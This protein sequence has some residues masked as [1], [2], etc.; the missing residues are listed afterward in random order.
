MRLTDSVFYARRMSRR[1]R[2]AAINR[3][4]RRATQIRVI[5]HDW[6]GGRTVTTRENVAAKTIR[7]MQGTEMRER[8]KTLALNTSREIVS[9]YI[10][11]T[12]SFY[13]A[14]RTFDSVARSAFDI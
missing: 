4:G 9:P 2:R 10:Q 11:R 12:L 6:N 1:P 7:A 14:F 8:K 3:A 5:I 13:R